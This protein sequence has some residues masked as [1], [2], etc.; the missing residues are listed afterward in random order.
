MTVEYMPKAYISKNPRN[1]SFSCDRLKQYAHNQ[2]ALLMFVFKCYHYP[3]K[4]WLSECRFKRTSSILTNNLLDL[5]LPAFSI[6]ALQ[7]TAAHRN[8]AFARDYSCYER[9]HCIFSA[10]W[11]A[12]NTFLY[13]TVTPTGNINLSYI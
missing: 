3:L 9:K 1:D 6:S 8:Y 11:S 7:S 12:A 2:F 10:I 4:I 5:A 13:S